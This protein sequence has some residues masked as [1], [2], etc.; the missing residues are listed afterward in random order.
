M[1]IDRHDCHVNVVLMA[2]ECCFR[3][4]GGIPVRKTKSNLFLEQFY[5]KNRHANYLLIC[6][7]IYTQLRRNDIFLVW[8]GVLQFHCSPQIY[9]GKLCGAVEHCLWM[10]Q[11]LVFAVK[12]L[13]KGILLQEDLA[14]YLA[15]ALSFVFVENL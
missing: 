10:N 3:S 6:I 4:C 7:L 5:T 1:M 2:S 15:L 9:I 11:P 8:T 13:L 14:L 12:K